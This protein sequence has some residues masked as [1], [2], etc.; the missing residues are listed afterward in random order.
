ML[1]D[2]FGRIHSYLRLSITDQCNLNCRYCIPPNGYR[3]VDREQI[4]RPEEI[5]RLAQIFADLGI[6]KIRLTGGEPLV[7]RGL[8]VILDQMTALDPSLEYAITTNGLL[9]EKW[10]DRLVAARVDRI[11]ISLDTLI[12]SRYAHINGMDGWR[13]VW[14]GF[15][16]AVQHPGV[17]KVKLNVVLQKGVNDEEIEEFARLTHR[18]PIHVRF[19]EMMPSHE[20]DWQEANMVKG[21]E[22][23]AKLPELVEVEDFP[24]ENRGPARMYSYP[25]APGMVGLISS[26]SKPVCIYCNRL[27]ITVRGILL[28]CLYNSAGLDLRSALCQDLLADIIGNRIV[29]FLQ[30]KEEVGVIP[31]HRDHG[32]YDSP[33]LATVGG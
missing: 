4:L 32:N 23:L 5:G 20:V 11:N 2:S 19:I 33:C 7:R 1:K 8:E 15:S 24:E 27:R 13:Q 22:V 25:G 31:I 9:L 14:N 3:K 6:R 17:K 28:C 12:Q 10:L 26:L 29:V 30:R 18:Y 21:S 16:A